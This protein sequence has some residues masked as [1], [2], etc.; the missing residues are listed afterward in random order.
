MDET[1]IRPGVGVRSVWVGWARR[2]VDLDEEI[3]DSEEA[4]LEDGDRRD[5][6]VEAAGVPVGREAQRATAASR[7]TLW[8]WD[9]KNYTPLAAW[10]QGATR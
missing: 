6:D 2:T 10:M 9:S 4:E 7:F 1:A 3:V 8:I 5:S